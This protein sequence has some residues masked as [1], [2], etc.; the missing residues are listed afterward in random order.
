MVE[1]FSKVK[2]YLFELGFDIQSE[3]PT[4]GLVVITDEDKGISNLV[5]DCEEEILVLEQFIFPL[6]SD[7]PQILKRLLQINREIVHGALALDEE[8]K[9]VIFRDTL[10]L[11]NL[12][13]NELEASV[14]AISLMLAEHA[15]EFIKFSK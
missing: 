8:G 13:L 5:I 2:D 11:K 1:H 4:E 3:D 10:Q 6:Q 15:N 9:K 14:N 7:D 12:D